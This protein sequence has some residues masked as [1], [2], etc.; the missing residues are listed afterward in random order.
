MFMLKYAIEDFIDFFN[1]RRSNVSTI[2][3]TIE[4]ISGC[5]YITVIIFT[6]AVLIE[7]LM[8]K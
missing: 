1:L 3:K 7:A 8:I 5:F 2:R 4:F 6:I